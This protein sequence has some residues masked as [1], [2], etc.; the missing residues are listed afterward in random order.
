ML[1]KYERKLILQGF[2]WFLMMFNVCHCCLHNIQLEKALA[3]KWKSTKQW[4]VRIS[5]MLTRVGW[6]SFQKKRL[7]LTS[8]ATNSYKSEICYCVSWYSQRTK[9]PAASFRHDI[10]EVHRTSLDFSG[11]H[12]SLPD[13]DVKGIALNFINCND[14]PWKCMSVHSVRL[15]WTLPLAQD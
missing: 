8:K 4:E 13:S 10:T 6:L 9:A 5:K 12:Q 14:S 2:D 1:M 11:H 7:W 15:L 3:A